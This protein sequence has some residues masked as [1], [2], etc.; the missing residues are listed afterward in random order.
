MMTSRLS[1]CHQTTGLVAANEALFKRACCVSVM[2]LPKL[3]PPV[4]KGCMPIRLAPKVRMNPFK[5]S[6]TAASALAQ[7][8]R[9]S[10]VNRAPSRPTILKLVGGTA[11][12]VSGERGRHGS[13]LRQRTVCVCDC[14]VRVAGNEQRGWYLPSGE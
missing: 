5:Y 8:A 12:H 2:V 4:R 13:E 1:R 9:P 3:H 14:L 11:I 6:S 10:L 7:R